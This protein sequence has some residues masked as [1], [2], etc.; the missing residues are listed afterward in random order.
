M[1]QEHEKA[2]QS[3]STRDEGKPALVAMRGGFGGWTRWSEEEH[4][5]TDIRECTDQHCMNV[6][7]NC[8]FQ[9]LDPDSPLSQS[10]G[11]SDDLRAAWR[12]KLHSEGKPT[13]GSKSLR[14]I[15][16]GAAK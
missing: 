15:I 11:V 6:E 9:G 1:S 5:K 13:S 2:L 16:F 4:T 7:V 3:D 10:A 12:S 14:D 8:G